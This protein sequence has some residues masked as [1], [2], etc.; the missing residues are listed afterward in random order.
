MSAGKSAAFSI[1]RAFDAGT[2]R[3]ERLRRGSD[4]SLGVVICGAEP[5]LGR[6]TNSVGSSTSIGAAPSR[7]RSSSNSAAVRPIWTLSRRT[8]ATAGW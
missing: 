4:R 5:Q 7:S 8:M 3:H 6:G 1:I 2:A